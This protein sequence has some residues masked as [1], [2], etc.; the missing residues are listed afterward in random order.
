MK[1]GDTNDALQSQ[2]TT[3]PWPNWAG[4]VGDS[5]GPLVRQVL[6]ADTGITHS[7][8]VGVE[9]SILPAAPFPADAGAHCGSH[10][11]DLTFWCRTDTA[12]DFITDIIKQ[13]Q[14]GPDFDVDCQK[15][16]TDAKPVGCH[17]FP[18][19]TSTGGNDTNHPKS[20]IELHGATCSNDCGCNANEFCFNPF[21]SPDN[22]SISTCACGA[23][24]TC[25]KG[26][27]L[28]TPDQSDAG[29]DA[30]RNCP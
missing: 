26:Q 11:N 20:F 8:I 7:I 1:I 30:G 6:D 12:T 27:C 3:V 9:S 5:G 14:L 16:G 28:T 17:V 18:D 4:C 24:C 25:L 23:D 10:Q 19:K 29:V 13:W 22:T 15:I 2:V 21:K